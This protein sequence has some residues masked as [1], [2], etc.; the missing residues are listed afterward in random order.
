MKD[1]KLALR[2]ARA[3][4][5][6]LPP[7]SDAAAVDGFLLS[8]AESLGASA[9]LRDSLLNPA[10]PK[11]ARRGVLSTLAAASGMPTQVGQFLGVIVENGRV[12]NLPSIAAAFHEAREAAEGV[13]A[14]TLTTAAP[15]DAT[16][17]AR[18]TASLERLTGRKVRLTATVDPS[19]LGGAVTQIGSTVYDG[20]LRTQLSRLRR[21]MA[22]E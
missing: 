18:A 20:S 14:A 7:G 10:I 2:Y 13:V 5:A 17:L 12:A 1:R 16:L 19:L 21:S 11:H 3:L 4:M 8:V 6:A 15:L 22:Q 9:E